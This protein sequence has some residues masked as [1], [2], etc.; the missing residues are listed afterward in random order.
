M[1]RTPFERPRY[2]TAPPAPPR[3]SE[4]AGVM[5]RADTGARPHPKAK[6][7]SSEAYRAAVRQLPCARCGHVGATQFCHTDEG[8]GLALKTDDRLGWA[9][10][11]PHDGTMGCH[12]LVGSS[13]HYSK[14][15][16]RCLERIYAQWTREQVQQL[17]LWPADLPAWEH[18]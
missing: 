4:R 12:Y 14:D 9:G 18:E 2:V 6:T 3:R 16:R 13:G 1:R 5:V 17:G 15:R 7:F 10:C 8:K 11:G